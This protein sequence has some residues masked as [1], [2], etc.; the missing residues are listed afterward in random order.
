[1]NPQPIVDAFLPLFREALA[2]P[3]GW[4]QTECEVVERDARI[5]LY[6]A[7]YASFPDGQTR[8][9]RQ[10]S[11]RRMIVETN[12]TLAEMWQTARQEKETAHA[13]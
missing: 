10:E 5:A 8:A 13:L 1:M 4:Q 7:H 3:E 2:A 12:R 9:E 6:H 11:I